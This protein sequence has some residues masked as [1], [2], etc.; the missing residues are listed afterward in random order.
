VC[1]VSRRQGKFWFENRYVELCKSATDVTM[2]NITPEI[3]TSQF[4][5]CDQIG[6]R[7]LR[8]SMANVR[9]CAGC[10]QPAE[11]TSCHCVNG[12]CLHC[13][14]LWSCTLV[15]STHCDSHCSKRDG[16]PY[17]NFFLFLNSITALTN[18]YYINLGLSIPFS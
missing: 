15:P 4:T 11:P 5:L 7:L 9:V 8:H 18:I 1:V 14:R 16:I 17:R 13:R 6:Q 3:K 10:T 12:S 2:Q